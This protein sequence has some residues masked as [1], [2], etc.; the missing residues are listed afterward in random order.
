MGLWGKRSASRTRGRS[1]KRASFVLVMS[2]ALT[3]AFARISAAAVGGFEIDA[4]QSATP[5]A[6]YSGNDSNGAGDDWAQ[7]ATKNGVFLPKATGT[8]TASD[9]WGSHIDKNTALPAGPVTFVCDGSSDSKLKAIN[10]EETTVGGGNK[11]TDTSWTKIAPGNVTGK[12]D[13]SQAYA[14]ASVVGGCPGQSGNDTVLRLAAFRGDNTGDTFWGF[15]FDQTP[16]DNFTAL[17]ANDGNGGQSFDLNFHRHAGDFLISYEVPG[18]SGTNVVLQVFQYKNPSGTVGNPENAGSFQLVNPGG[19]LPGCT[20]LATNDNHEIQAPPWNVPTCDATSDGGGNTCRIAN[21]TN[22]LSTKKQLIAARDFEEASIDLTALG[23]TPCVSTFIFTSR[24]S[25]GS[26]GT[27]IGSAQLKDVG[28]GD[29][30][31]C[32]S[33][34]GVKFKDLNADGLKGTNDPGL[35]GWTIKLYQDTNSN[36][37]LDATDLANQGTGFPKS[38]TTATVSGTDGSYKFANLPSGDYIICEVLQSTWTQSTPSNQVC[39]AGN[40]PLADGG[41]A[42]NLAGVDVSGQNFGNFQNGSISGVKFKDANA[43][44][45]QDTSEYNATTGAGGLGGWTIKLYQDNNATGGVGDG[46]LT[47]ADTQASGWPKTTTTTTSATSTNGTYS[48]T[49][50]PPGDY[51]VCEVVDNAPAGPSNTPPA[52]THVGWVQSYPTASTTGSGGCTLSGAELGAR[53]WPVTVTSGSSTT[54]Q[55]IGNTP[56]SNITVTF[57]PLAKLPDGTTAA[58]KATSISCVDKGAGTGSGSVGSNTNSNTKTTD[59]VKLNQSSV[60]CTI[61]YTDP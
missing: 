54:A 51:V 2:I 49:G 17:K 52:E 53:G 61:T 1:K 34:S 24:A 5:N 4:D 47:S 39:H 40:P 30:N 14:Y 12:D 3:F 59:D 46:S 7:G 41:F 57:N 11:Q 27:D 38:T 56:L 36:Q 44:G 35:N 42:V 37:T 32:S 33:I 55:N 6:L 23:I 50:V 26:G 22:A 13:V 28:G 29:F 31:L 45:L 21:G 15:E 9:C 58:T 10:D 48:F 19:S 25:S 16:P 60:V 43:N 18:S 20:R 8:G